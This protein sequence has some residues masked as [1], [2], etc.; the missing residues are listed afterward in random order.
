MKRRL[1]KIGIP[2]VLALVL[3]AAAFAWFSAGGG[4]SGSASAANPTVAITVAPG[5]PSAK[6]FP[7][8]SADVATTFTNANGFP[9]HVDQLLL[10]T[11]QGTNGFAVDG[12]HSS[13]NVS[14][15]GYT[16][17]SAGWTVPA[18]AGTTD[19][20]LD[21]D[22]ASA[23]SMGASAANACQGAT[24]TVYLKVAP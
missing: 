17:Q 3:A 18:K 15:L 24:F 12:S 16:T 9:V 1:L 4:G 19:G 21:V 6:L 8:G 5:T 11:S 23:I 7:G 22:L 20:T 10:D 13:C 14:T 2:S